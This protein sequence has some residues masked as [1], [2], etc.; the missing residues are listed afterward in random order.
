MIPTGVIYAKSGQSPSEGMYH[1]LD[2]L[3]GK[4]IGVVQGTYFDVLTKN[5]LPDAEILYY[6]TTADQV[7]ALE[8]HKIDGLVA[9]M[10]VLRKVLKNTESVTYLDDPL[11]ESGFGFIFPKTDKGRKLCDEFSEYIRNIKADGTLKQLDD[12]WFGDD[13]AKKRTVR[14]YSPEG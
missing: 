6:P 7:K 4:Q 10:P 1:S 5:R 14:L 8:T 11:E 2:E 3:N 9:E 13:D 12:V